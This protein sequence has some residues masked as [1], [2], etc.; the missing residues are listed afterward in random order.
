MRTYFGK[1]V[2]ECV[3]NTY[4]VWSSVDSISVKQAVLPL[5][6]IKLTIRPSELALAMLLAILKFSQILFVTLGI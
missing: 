1:P 5:P 6:L 4:S 3:S 2:E